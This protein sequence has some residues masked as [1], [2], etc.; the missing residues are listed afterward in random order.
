M[1]P[2]APAS[3][4][5]VTHAGDLKLPDGLLLESGGEYLGDTGIPVDLGSPGAYPLYFLSYRTESYDQPA[6][7]Q[8]VVDPDSE[9]VHWAEDDR[10][11]SGTDGGLNW[12]GSPAAAFGAFVAVDDPGA[13]EAFFKL[14]DL[15]YERPCVWF[16]V[17]SV[18]ASA[19]LFSNGFGDGWTPAAAG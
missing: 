1:E 4:F 8:L 10:F 12:I 9:P 3:D 11:G 18:G 15:I 16:E 6:F 7:A 13:E 17:P 14:Y 19:I 5:F 2:R